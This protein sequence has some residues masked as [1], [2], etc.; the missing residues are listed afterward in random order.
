MMS[1]LHSCEIKTGLYR[2]LYAR[3]MTKLLFIKRKVT[4]FVIARFIKLTTIINKRDLVGVKLY[5]YCSS[6]G[7]NPPEVLLS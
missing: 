7:I 5:K 2:V 4:T 3:G 1:A 6:G